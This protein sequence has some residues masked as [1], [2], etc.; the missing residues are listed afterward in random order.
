MPTRTDSIEIAVRAFPETAVKATRAHRSWTRPDVVF[1]F[2]TETTTDTSQRLLFGSYRVLADGRCFEEGLFAGDDLSRRERRILERYASR[3]RAATHHDDEALPL[4]TLDEFLHRFFTIVYKGRALCV[5]FNLPF[6]LSRIARRATEARGPFEGGF[7]FEY[8]QF[9]DKDGTVRASSHRPR[10][11]VKHIDS[12]RALIGFGGRRSPDESDLIPE[13][14]GDGRPQSGFVFQG[15]FLD[16][17]RLAF[18]LTDRGHT[19]DSACEAFGVPLRKLPGVQ[20]GKV[21]EHYIDYNRLDVEVTAALA[22]KLLAEYERHPIGL[23][24]TQ[25]YSPASIGKAYLAAMGIPPVL[26]RQPD[27]PAEY[28]GFAQSAFY[29]GRTSAHIRKV[30]VPVV[31]TDFLSMYP[32]VNVLMGLWRFVTARQIVVVPNCADEIRRF[33]GRISLDRC[34]DSKL[35]TRL[36][37]FVRIRPNADFLPIRARFN[38]A[39]RD[40]QVAMSVLTADSDA[41][42]LWYA[43]PDVIASVLRTGRVP[44]IVDAFR[45][46]AKGTLPDL[47]PTELRGAMDI[48][49]KTTDF[50][51]TVVEERTRLKGRKDVESVRTRDAS[52]VLVNSTSYGIFAEMIRADS[53]EEVTVVCRG[54]DADAFSCRVTHPEHPGTCCFPPLAALITAGARLMLALLDEEVRRRGG[55]YAMED[56]DSMAVVATETGGLIPCPGGNHTLSDGSAAIRALSWQDVREIVGRFEALNPYD[57]SVVRQSVL[58]IE[59]DNLDPAT[60]RQ[61]PIEC[62][63]ISAKRY[64]LFTRDERG[65]PVLL[66]RHGPTDKDRWSEH[67]LGH[68]LNPTDPESDDRDWIADVWLG[69][70]RR[71]LGLKASPHRFADRPAVGR[72]GVTSPVLLRPFEAFNEGKSYSE[73]VK[74]FNFGLSCRARPFGQPVGI[75]GNRFHLFSPYERDPKRWLSML[76]IDRYSGRSFHVTTSGQAGTRDAARVETYADVLQGY[77]CSPEAKCADALGRPC[78]PQTLGL[79]QA[80]HV[81]IDLIRYIGKE[82]NLLESVGDGLVDDPTEAYTE[83]VDESRDEWNARTRPA[84]RRVSLGE[85]QRKTGLSRRMLIDARSGKRRPRRGHREMLTEIALRRR[86][87]Q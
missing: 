75:K 27:F 20:H 16:L 58:K 70:V 19:L 61:R 81:R 57:R 64:A 12:K 72:L 53:T 23:S 18:A 42:A 69:I 59:D 46:K 29:G 9:E 40:W 1:V 56:T 32:T 13:S 83:Y 68:L 5:A 15:H 3:H 7:S 30:P 4:L 63:A 6:D 78:N 8:W 85:L 86:R 45:L 60:G 55:T 50:F 87:G 71:A 39:T 49:P 26:A 34:F 84:L 80:R 76:W 21:T 44:T 67:G 2:D 74:P 62:L 43:L 73:S 31:Y 28:L 66:R 41:D 24:P 51:R 77:E 17:R 22:F 54:L 82:S 47:R 25:A 79:L 38:E 11:R 35:W 10:V 48:D 14:S 33:L 37:A 52:K 36:P 65:E